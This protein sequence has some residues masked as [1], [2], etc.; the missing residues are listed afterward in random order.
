MGDQSNS[1]YYSNI[2]LENIDSDIPITLNFTTL[3]KVTQAE[4]NQVTNKLLTKRVHQLFQILK[5][6]LQQI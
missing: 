3:P 4:D 6:T 1:T 5:D 2:L